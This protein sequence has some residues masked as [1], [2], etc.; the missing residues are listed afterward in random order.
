MEEAA[1]RPLTA[2]LAPRPRRRERDV[3][4]TSRARVDPSSTW[5]DDVVA[6]RAC[7]GRRKTSRVAGEVRLKALSRVLERRL[8]EAGLDSRSTRPGSSALSSVRGSGASRVLTET[9]AELAS[10]PDRKLELSLLAK[11]FRRGALAAPA[12]PK[13]HGHALSR[14]ALRGSHLREPR[15][16]GAAALE[17]VA[18]AAAAAA[19]PAEARAAASRAMWARVDKRLRSDLVAASSSRCVAQPAA[20]FQGPA[21]GDP[22]ASSDGGV[23]AAAAD[24]APA[25][26]GAG[27]DPGK[28]D[29]SALI[30]ELETMLRCFACTGRPARGGLGYG[31]ALRAALGRPARVVPGPPLAE[32]ARVPPP[33]T[34]LEAF[35]AAVLGRGKLRPTGGPAPSPAT[36]SAAALGGSA[37]AMLGGARSPSKYGAPG[38]ASTALGAAAGAGAVA[39][40]EGSTSGAPATAAGAAAG[41]EAGTRRRRKTAGGAGAAGGGVVASSSAFGMAGEHASRGHIDSSD[42]E[43]DAASAAT[44]EDIAPSSAE[45]GGALAGGLADQVPTAAATPSGSAVS[46]DVPAQLGS[47]L[48]GPPGALGAGDEALAGAEDDPSD[49]GADADAESVASTARARHRGKEVD[50]A[51][52]G[53]G[54]AGETA[55]WLELR[56]SSP[57]HRR[58]AQGVAQFLGLASRAV[59]PSA[60]LPGRGPGAAG[61]GRRAR[62]GEP[63]A[64]AARRRE[65]AAADAAKHSPACAVLVARTARAE[66]AA[67]GAFGGAATALAASTPSAAAGAASSVLAAIEL[68][69]RHGGAARRGMSAAEAVAAAL[70]ARR[71]VVGR[72]RE[73]ATLHVGAPEESGANSETTVEDPRIETDDE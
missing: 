39:S 28:E 1:L 9:M 29:G 33:A 11:D 23:A 37:A 42:D 24:S 20:P 58:V 71:P 65:R 45:R 44:G 49:G 21:H 46:R 59:E 36:G 17:R 61:S 35:E 72:T 38:G 34:D 14:T 70:R 26:S 2:G 25:A 32:A 12:A 57:F 13:G 6:P 50:A 40:A 52:G 16:E 62:R 8:A 68:D 48:V 54:A 27:A 31:R 56:L 47:E 4:A 69:V 55:D 15:G 73:G 66:A 19:S 60:E 10:D 53:A 7:M 64:K 30:A 51:D 43:S 67:R 41:A 63:G 5:M 3:S 18:Q 22:E